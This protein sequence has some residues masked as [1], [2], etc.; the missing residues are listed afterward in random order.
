MLS[1][2]STLSVLRTLACTAAFTLAALAPAVALADL[3]PPEGG[4]IDPDCTVD[5]QAVAGE[6]CATCS[7]AGGTSCQ[8]ELGGDYNFVCQQ[9]TNVQIWCNGP[10]RTQTLTSSCAL[11]TGAAAPFGGVAVVAAAL[12][13]WSRRR[14]VA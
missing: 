14:R 1:T 9:S 8:T 13:L 12:A 7:T 3:P 2:L 10:D 5:S 4:T 6:S 11:G